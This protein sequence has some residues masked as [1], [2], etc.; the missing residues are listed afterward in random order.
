MYNSIF[1]QHFALEA[2]EYIMMSETVHCILGPMRLS[3]QLKK[4]VQ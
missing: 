2:S 4:N 1:S 3:P